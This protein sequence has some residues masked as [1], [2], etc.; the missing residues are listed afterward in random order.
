[1]SDLNFDND[2]A[3]DFNMDEVEDLPQYVREIDGV[4]MCDLSLSR[5]TGDRDGKPYDFLVMT[6]IIEEELEVKKDHGVS[7]DDIVVVRN[8]LLPTKRDIDNKERV[9]F[10][11]KIAKPFLMA[12]KDSLNTSGQ[13]ADIVKE[14]Q[15]VKCTATFAT[16]HSKGQNKDGET[17]EHANIT[18]KKLIVS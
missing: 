3:A 5:D 10:G 12:L 13:L 11:V 2:T 18:L 6:F 9:P 17:V 16:K 14:A 15:S 4:Y 8:S 1:M 7:V